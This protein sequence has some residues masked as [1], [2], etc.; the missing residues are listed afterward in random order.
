MT[1]VKDSNR[2]TRQSVWTDEEFQQRARNCKSQMEM[3]KINTVANK[4]NDLSTGPSWDLTKSRKEL[5]NWR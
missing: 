1:N 2:K 4:Q 3:L 5:V